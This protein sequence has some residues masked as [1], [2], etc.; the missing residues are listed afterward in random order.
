[1]KVLVSVL[2]RLPWIILNKKATLDTLHREKHTFR[3]PH[4]QGRNGASLGIEM[5]ALQSLI[6]F[7]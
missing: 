2:S 4:P 5:S 7:P 6:P 1:M 3:E